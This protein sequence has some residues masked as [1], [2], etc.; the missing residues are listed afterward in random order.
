MTIARITTLGATAALG[1]GLVLVPTMAQA[2][3]VTST[4]A[5]QQVEAKRLGNPIDQTSYEQQV[6]IDD[7]IAATGYADFRMVF[8]K[9]TPGATVRVTVNGATST[10]VANAKGVARVDVRFENRINSVAVQ[11]VK[12]HQKSAVNTSAYDFRQA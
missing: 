4:S 6:Q 12:G 9:A 1:L 7:Q 11:Q 2:A 5:A 3:P 8:K 10:G